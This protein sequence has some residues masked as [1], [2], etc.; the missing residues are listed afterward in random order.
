MFYIHT[1]KSVIVYKHLF[2]LLM[3]MSL[4]QASNDKLSHRRNILYH[5]VFYELPKTESSL[6]PR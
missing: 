2:I 5:L 1:S 4:S 3:S 6:S